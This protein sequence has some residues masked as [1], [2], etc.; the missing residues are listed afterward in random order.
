MGV[1]G[2]EGGGIVP[3]RISLNISFQA[4]PPCV[5]R[6][7]TDTRLRFYERVIRDIFRC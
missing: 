2:G 5:V 4:P 7:R 3:R 1:V 6:Y